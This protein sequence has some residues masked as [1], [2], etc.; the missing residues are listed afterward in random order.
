MPEDEHVE[1]VR[2]CRRIHKLL[3][4]YL[5]S[6]QAWLYDSHTDGLGYH[7][8]LKGDAELPPPAQAEPS[9]FTGVTS[10]ELVLEDELGGF[11]EPWKVA[12]HALVEYPRVGPPR[13]ILLCSTCCH[14]F[15]FDSRNH[16][17]LA[18][19]CEGKHGGGREVENRRHFD[20]LRRPQT[21]RADVR[22]ESPR[23]PSGTA[24]DI[25]LAAK[26]WGLDVKSCSTQGPLKKHKLLDTAKIIR[27]CGLDYQEAVELGRVVDN[28][29]ASGDSD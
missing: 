20:N 24:R 17:G 21:S 11:L 6:F 4:Q 16:R 12:G 19:K 15:C 7:F 29:D 13:F 9:E 1:F 10:V 23:P 2:G 18:Q 25:F 26:R 14:Y 8:P 27:A 3:L 5:G 22:L 28:E